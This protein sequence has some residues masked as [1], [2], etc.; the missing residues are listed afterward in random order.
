MQSVNTNP[1]IMLD[2]LHT[3]KTEEDCDRIR[4]DHDSFN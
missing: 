3:G 2:S 1:E 4:V